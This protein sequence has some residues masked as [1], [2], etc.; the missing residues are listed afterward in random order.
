M[1]T[2]V[3]LSMRVL[4]LNLVIPRACELSRISSQ[5][6]LIQAVQPGKDCMPFGREVMLKVP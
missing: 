6:V 4:D 1:I 5:T 2:I 3:L